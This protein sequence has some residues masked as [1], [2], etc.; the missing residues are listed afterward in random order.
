MA[1][2]DDDGGDLH[3]E[4]LEVDLDRRS[5]GRLPGER[6]A[7]SSPA[8]A[9]RGAVGERAR[10]RRR[11]TRRLGDD[12]G[13]VAGDLAERGVAHA[14]RPA[15]RRPSP[16]ARAARSPRS[17]TAGRGRGAAVERGE[18]GLLDVA[19]QVGAP[20]AQLGGERRLL[21]GP[22]DD[23][24]QPDRLRPPRRRPAG[25]CAPGSRRRR[26]GS[27]R[28]RRRRARTRDRRRAGSRRRA[29]ASP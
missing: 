6:R 14:P 3:A 20:A 24:R 21:L 10:G 25:P 7:R 29:R 2:R 16:R 8:A 27:R 15:S 19:A 23:E 17:A 11:R 9:Q 5:R 1:V 26:A 13:G 4:R 22:D 28:R 12:D 18:L